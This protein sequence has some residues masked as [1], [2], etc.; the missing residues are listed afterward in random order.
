MSTLA[1][2]DNTAN[3]GGN[4]LIV[5]VFIGAAR[6]AAQGFSLTTNGV[7]NGAKAFISMSGAGVTETAAS[8]LRIETDVTGKPSG[9]LVDAN[10]QVIYNANV[11]PVSS[12]AYTVVSFPGT[13][14]LTATTPYWLVCQ[15]SDES[16]LSA[17]YHQMGYFTGASLYTDGTLGKY[18]GGAWALQASSD[19]SFF[20]LGVDAG[21]PVVLNKTM[22]GWG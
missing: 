15:H 10:A 1:S 9:V 6:R 22:M 8:V 19:S 5:G 3:P 16:D 2:Y 7:C 18:S 12:W 17:Q 4:T 21:A 13:F 11:I 14:T 20:V